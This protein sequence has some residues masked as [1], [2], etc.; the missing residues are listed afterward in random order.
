MQ[1]RCNTNKISVQQLTLACAI[2]SLFNKQ[3]MDCIISHLDPMTFEIKNTINETVAKRL[4]VDRVPLTIQGYV[5]EIEGGKLVVSKK[6][7]KSSD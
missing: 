3:A 2:E 7:E 5:G 4:L 1:F 6:A